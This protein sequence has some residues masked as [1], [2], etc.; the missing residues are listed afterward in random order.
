[1][2]RLTL[3]GYSWGG[4]LSLLYATEHPARVE[5]LALVSPAPAWRAARGEFERRLSARTMAPAL[6]QE[7]AALRASGLRES[8]P[9]AYQRR[10]F[11]LSVAAAF[12]TRS[13]TDPVPRHRPPSRRC[14][15]H[16]D[17]DAPSAGQLRQPSC[18]T[19]ATTRFGRIGPGHRGCAPF[20][21]LTGCGHVP[22][23]EA[24]D[25]FRRL[26]DDFLPS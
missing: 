3:A 2:E 9:D 20:H 15:R 12:P 19:A 21:L 14:G 24:F 5:R 11:E 8:D 7:R 4:L 26:L 1:M 25:E 18:C 23:V 16:G 6:Q 22:Y 10:V 13:R 17:Y